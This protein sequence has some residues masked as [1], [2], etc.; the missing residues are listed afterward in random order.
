MTTTTH[1]AE[2]SEAPSVGRLVLVSNRLPVSIRLAHG[3]VE[4]VPSAGGL[5]TGLRGPHEKTGG[6]WIGWPGDVAAA[7]PELR[8]TV[9]ARLA[10]LR[11]VPVHLSPGDAR[12]F[13]EGYSNGVLWP[14]FHS[15]LDRVPLHTRDW[16][17]YVH[18]NERFADVV[19]EHAN[20]GDSIWVH[21]YQLM[22]LPSMLRRRLPGAR[23]GFFLH[24]PFPS[25]EVFRTLPSREKLLEGL[26]GADLIGFHTFAY[27]RHFAT[28][29]LRILGIEPGVDRVEHDG[30]YVRL[31]V[32]PM[33]IDGDA[34]ARLADDPEIVAEAAA[35]RRSAPGTSILLGVD[36]L[37]YTKG[38]L[39]RM[40][41]VERLLE[42]QP[43]L[44]GRVRLM[45]LAVPSRE[46]VDEYRG[47][48]EQLERL[49]GRIN[50]AYSTV[51]GAPIHYMYRSVSQRQLVAMY[52]AAD[53]MVVTPLRD[54]MNLVCKEFVASR[55]DGD[56]VLVLSELAG[57]ASELG[58]AILVNPYDIDGTAAALAQAIAMPEAERRRRMAA[59]RAR[60]MSRSVH[61]WAKG[62][63]AA[64]ASEPAVPSI[65]RR[66]EPAEA[67][68]ECIGR[69][70]D[71]ALLLDYDGT[72]VPLVLRPEMATPDPA[73]LELLGALAALPRCAV[74]VASGRSREELT[75]WLG[76]LP[77]GLHAEHGVWSRSPRGGRWIANVEVNGRW[78]ELVRPVLEEYAARTPGAIVE[79]KSACIAWHYRAADAQLGTLQAKELRLHLVEALAQQP[80]EILTGDK[81][82]EVRPH[83]ASKGLASRSVRKSVPADALLVAIGDDRTDED[84]FAAL[85]SDAIT[86]H[87]GRKPA[88]ASHRLGAPSDV[89]SLL[90]RIVEVRRRLAAEAP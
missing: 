10:E 87:V 56:G 27:L 35:I 11:V 59:L 76:A 9:E 19:A 37:D 82:L 79:D 36:R 46:K 53:A 52:R 86:I 63:L 66:P 43:S 47:F 29:L 78:K 75:Q 64:L 30:R 18:A 54:G 80:L 38:L 50:G 58:E 5:A 65:E 57:A 14:L 84:M 20:E 51:T 7:D 77:L 34:F 71:L 61:D 70:R 21:D 31:G 69:A 13:Y 1:A 67:L 41:V 6:L 83:G 28:S 73:L 68:G 17:A 49:V 22:L 2:T 15:M 90:W 62:F 40:L 74:H 25:S 60:V 26:L 45:Q 4:V 88:R 12:R 85:P 72:L 33:G 89:R 8:R 3:R 39:R 32:F 81:V 44:R 42:R 55:A 16:D 23:I 24:V 48:R